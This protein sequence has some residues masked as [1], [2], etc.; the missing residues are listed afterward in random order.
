MTNQPTNCN[1][2]A[3]LNPPLRYVD[4]GGVDIQYQKQEQVSGRSAGLWINLSWIWI[5]PM[6]GILLSKFWFFT[7]NP[8]R[9]WCKRSTD[10][11]HISRWE[12]LKIVLV[13]FTRNPTL[14]Y[15]WLERR[16]YLQIIW[17]PTISFPD[18]TT[19][20]I[21]IRPIETPTKPLNLVKLFPNHQI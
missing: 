1:G 11:L 16:H 17:F 5:T 3:S 18:E 12:S 4:S 8:P 7:Q 2:H 21:K 10:Y 20:L 19:W 15:A 13:L 14:R 9:G 6:I